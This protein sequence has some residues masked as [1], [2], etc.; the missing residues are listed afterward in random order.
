M[1]GKEQLSGAFFDLD[2]TLHNNGEMINSSFEYAIATLGYEEKTRQEISGT[3]GLNLVDSYKKLF[4]EGNIDE[5]CKLHRLFQKEH[6]ELLSAYP[7]TISTLDKIRETGTKIAV[8]TNRARVYTIDDMM[9]TGI[10]EKIDFLITRD[11]VAKSKPDPE[12]INTAL[13][14]FKIKPSNACMVGDTEIDVAAGRAAGVKTVGLT[15]NV[16]AIKD[17]I[18]SRPNYLI[19]NITEMMPIILLQLKMTTGSIMTS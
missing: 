17:L 8:I 18:E 10:I 6:P 12:G 3:F 14:Y 1:H 11:D 13:E 7:N 15:S 16:L 9:A 4:P 2:G 19:D 5:L